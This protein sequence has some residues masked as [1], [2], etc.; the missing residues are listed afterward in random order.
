VPRLA[1]LLIPLLIAAQMLLAV[2]AMA[3]APAASSDE[4]PCHEMPMPADHCPGCPDGADSMN[5][6]LAACMLAVAITSEFVVVRVA[7]HPATEFVD[8]FNRPSSV[9]DPPLKPP[10]IA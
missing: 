2:P 10:P 6:C 3:S 1:K 4:V 8:S 5:D 7:P 9:F